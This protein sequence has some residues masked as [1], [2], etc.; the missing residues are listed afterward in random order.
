MQ[1]FIS[2]VKQFSEEKGMELP[3][4]FP[5]DHPIEK[6]SR[7]MLAACIKHLSQGEFLFCLM[8]TLKHKSGGVVSY[9]SLDLVSQNRIILQQ[10]IA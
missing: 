7:A 1:E 6:A 8:F 3:I 9:G 10:S 2:T 5:V 4:K